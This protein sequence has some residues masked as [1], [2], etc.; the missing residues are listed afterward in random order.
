MIEDDHELLPRIVEFVGLAENMSRRT[1]LDEFTAEYEDWAIQACISKL[2]AK[3]KLV[4]LSNWDGHYRVAAHLKPIRKPTDHTNLGANSP[5]QKPKSEEVVV[6]S[7]T[8]GQKGRKPARFEL[9]PPEALEK[10]ARAY[11]YGAEKYSDDNWRKGYDWS[12]SYGAMQ[13]HLNAF[14]AGEDTDESGHP[15]LAHAAFHVLT[16]L[17]Y[18]TQDHYRQFDDR[19]RPPEPARQWVSPVARAFEQLQKGLQR[20]NDEGIS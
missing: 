17:V 19:P 9:I 3:G 13:R 6:T 15:H 14:W 4:P 20:I 1:I 11:G 10:V 12:L 2:V 18:S 8:G 7:E 5:A 16:L